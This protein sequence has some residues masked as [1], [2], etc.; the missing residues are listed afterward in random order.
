VAQFFVWGSVCWVVNGFF[1]WSP[2]EPNAS[3]LL[4]AS[5]SA[6]A[7]GTL[8]ECGAAFAVLE[9][10]NADHPWELGDAVEDKVT[11]AELDS[12]AIT[13]YH[14]HNKPMGSRRGTTTGFR[15]WGT[16]WRSLGYIAAFTQLCAATVF[17]ISTF[18]GLP[19]LVD[20][21]THHAPRAVLF[22]TPQVVG[23]SGFVLAGI[24][25]LYELQPE[26]T[27]LP[28]L[29]ELG[30]HVAAWNM[31]GALGF[32]LSG[33]FGYAEGGCCQH[34]GTAFST[35]WGGWAFLLGSYLQ[36]LE[37]VNKHPH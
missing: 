5:W 1:L 14:L 9:A 10:L 32:T 2:T 16:D 27:L 33:A 29:R 37:V 12:S 26:G 18:T 8:F 19:N 4:A 13:H 25:Q 34:W 31:V 28:P 22:W 20:D 6:F 11:A 23:G 36:L 7:G 15:W 3:Q 24:V 21:P 30:W 35:F 17:W